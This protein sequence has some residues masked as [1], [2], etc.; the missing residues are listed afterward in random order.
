[1]TSTR[2]RFP[3]ERQ[4]QMIDVI[5]ERKRVGTAELAKLLKISLPTV[6]RD[7][8]VLEQAGIVARTH[9]GVVARGIGEGD[10]EPLFLEKVR[11]HQTLKQRI[12][13]KAAASIE[14]GQVALLDSGTTALATAHALAGRRITVV[15]MDIKVAEAAAVGP[16]EVHIVGGRV[17]NGY[18]SLVG[19]WAKT[20]LATIQAD[21]CFIAADAI[22]EGSVTTATF[23]EAETKRLAMSRAKRTVVITDHSKFGKR[24]FAEVCGLDAIDELITDRD[25]EDLIAPYRKL[26]PAITLA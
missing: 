24:V 2:H 21:I 23:D 9:G 19:N 7:L 12:G 10:T 6:R 15:T 25:A 1:M 26:I 4:Q 18:F 8:T 17:R 3:Q 14:D 13:Q 20:A 22:D 16:T 11:H 5:V